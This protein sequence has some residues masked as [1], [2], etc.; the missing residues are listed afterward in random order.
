MERIPS[1]LWS[2]WVLPLGVTMLMLVACA[3][4][5]T[6]MLPPLQVVDHVDLN[7]YA[8]EW[9]EIA[10]YPH[11]FQKGCVVSKATY[12][13]DDGGIE[14][15]NECFEQA[16]AGPVRSVTGR[17]R[18][19][20]ETTNAKLKVTFFWP[21]YGDYWIIDLDDDYR[22]AVVGHPT[23]KYL[24]ILSRTRQ[25]EETLYQAILVRLKEQ[26]YDTAKLIRTIRK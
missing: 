10:R 26:G 25:M 11:G 9:F 6:A 2:G 22:Y 19:I 20:D 24:W 18:V 21:F 13:V 7:R 3:P 5:E 12:S 17:A 1:G 14:V 16:E 15:V 23:R 8:G 4:P